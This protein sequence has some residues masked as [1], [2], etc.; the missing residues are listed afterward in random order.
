MSA[1]EMESD[2]REGMDKCVAY[3]KEELRGVRTGRAS[4]GLVEHLKVE[5]AAYGSTMALRELATIS[6]PDAV[7][8]LIKP[9][10]P[11][12]VKDIEKAIQSS[13]LGISPATDGRVIRLPIPPLSGERRTQLTIQVKK[14][15]ETQKVAI[16]LV[17]STL[18]PE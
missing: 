5:V 1:G 15:G 18:R 9:F 17:A 8:V 11:S 10:D 6:T 4:P 14:L 16:R 12:T 2:C 3:L 13:E 7:T